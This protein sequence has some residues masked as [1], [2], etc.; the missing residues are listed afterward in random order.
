MIHYANFSSSKRLQRVHDLLNQG[1]EHSTLE[2]SIRAGVCAVS[3]IMSELRAQGADI[4]CRQ[5]CSKQ[6]GEQIWVYRLVSP[7]PAENQAVGP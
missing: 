6:T 7:V 5:I 4:R 1:G 3:S 2:I